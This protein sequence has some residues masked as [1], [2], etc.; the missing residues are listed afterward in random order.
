MS[1]WM[2]VNPLG[3]SMISSSVM[4]AAGSASG[5][6][7]A[8][9]AKRAVASGIRAADSGDATVRSALEQRLWDACQGFEAFWL[10]TVFQTMRAN[11]LTGKSFWGDGPGE[12]IFNGMLDEE[13]GRAAAQRGVGIGRLLYQDMVRRLRPAADGSSTPN[14]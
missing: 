3:A 12:Q 2:G 8:L 5:F 7:A 10:G 1:Q 4:P 11:S 14:F 6:A 13:W 9:A